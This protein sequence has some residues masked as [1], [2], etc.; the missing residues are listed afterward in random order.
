MDNS[1]RTTDPV[2]IGSL[3][4]A[5]YIGLHRN[6]LSRLA[7]AGVIKTAIKLPGRTGS[8]LFDVLELDRFKAANYRPGIAPQ[9]DAVT[10]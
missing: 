1:P 9:Y 5:E 2:L 3:E 4:A 7:Q 10:S 8:R 6:S